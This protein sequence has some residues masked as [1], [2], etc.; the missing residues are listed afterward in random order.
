MLP[1][2]AHSRPDQ[3]EANVMDPERHLRQTLVPHPEALEAATAQK[4][5]PLYSVALTH[6]KNRSIW[7]T[8]VRVEAF[9]RLFEDRST[10]LDVIERAADV[11]RELNP[12]VPV[13]TA[14]FVHDDGGRWAAFVD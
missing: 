9:P 10:A 3:I 14:F 13:Q 7:T 11:A 2:A 6:N 5:K 4:N 8:D 12:E 1:D